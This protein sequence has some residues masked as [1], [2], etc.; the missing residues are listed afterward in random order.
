MNNRVFR[1]TIADVR[2]HREIKLATTKSR[3][4]YLLSEPNY[5]TAKCFSENV[6]AIEMKSNKYSWINQFI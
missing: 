2:R 4:N 1:K 6:L 3:R 5:D